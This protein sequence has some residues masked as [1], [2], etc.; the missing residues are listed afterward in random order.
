MSRLFRKL[1]VAVLLVLCIAIHA[2]EASGHWD[3]TLHE[4]ND[5]AGLIAVVLCVGLALFVA[6]TLLD[7]LR[8]ASV[9]PR[10]I[11]A[12]STPLHDTFRVVQPASTSSP[13]LLL[14]I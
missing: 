11:I 9:V 4:A 1:F 13:P 14:R 7:R 3:R 12:A 6:G 2:L 8:S 10:S 5:E